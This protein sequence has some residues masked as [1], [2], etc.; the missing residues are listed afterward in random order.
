MSSPLSI[1]CELLAPGEG[2]EVSVYYAGG[3]GK[4]TLTV[5]SVITVHH[6]G[7]RG[8][9]TILEGGGSGAP[10]L[11]CSLSFVCWVPTTLLAGSHPCCCRTCHSGR[12]I[13]QSA[14]SSVNT[15]L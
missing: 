8:W 2:E 11:D 6:A 5:F 12:T 9:H 10:H 7:G 3:G 4:C 15:K 14:P 1:Y 13:A